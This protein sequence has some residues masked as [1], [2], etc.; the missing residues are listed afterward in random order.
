MTSVGTP[1]SIDPFKALDHATTY[2]KKHYPSK[3]PTLQHLLNLELVQKTN[4]KD[5]V[6]YY[7]HRELEIDLILGSSRRFRKDCIL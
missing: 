7:E 2:F 5:Y 4:C 3:F 1:S 6:E